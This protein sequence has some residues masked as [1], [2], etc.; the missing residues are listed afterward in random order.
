MKMPEI[1]RSMARRG[2][3]TH[4]EGAD[5]LDRLIH[6]L[7]SDLRRGRS[8]ALPGLGHFTR[9]ERGRIAFKREGKLGG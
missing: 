3:V 9:D 1:A 5:R 6:Q 2:G 4:A 8:V 7:L